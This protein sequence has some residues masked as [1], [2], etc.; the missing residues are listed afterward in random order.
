MQRLRAGQAGMVGAPLAHDTRCLH[1]A[2]VG[3]FWSHGLEAADAA[4]E[5]P[6]RM[7]RT[8]DHGHVRSSPRAAKLL[9]NVQEIHEIMVPNSGA[10]LECLTC[11]CCGHPIGSGC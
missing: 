3:S 11:A 8:D 1:R 10:G 4:R 5:W 6:L 7:Q 2:V 9:V